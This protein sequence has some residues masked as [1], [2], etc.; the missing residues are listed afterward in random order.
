MTQGRLGWLEEQI[1]KNPTSLIQQLLGNNAVLR[2]I[3][4]SNATRRDLALKNLGFPEQQKQTPQQETFER[5][6]PKS[7]RT[8]IYEKGTNKPLRWKD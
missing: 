2:E 8:G 3:R 7:G 4:D 1:K 5:F 6:D